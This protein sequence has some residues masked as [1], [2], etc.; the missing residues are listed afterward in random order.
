MSTRSNVKRS[1]LRFFLLVFALSTPFWLIGVVSTWQLLPGV[2][3]SALQIAC[4]TLAAML[5]VY[6]ESGGGAVGQLLKRSFDYERI[7]ARG[8]L[9]P[10]LLLMPAV[11]FV[12]Y[13]AMR[14][15]GLPLPVVK[16]NWSF[17]VPLFLALFL[18]G[19]AEELGWS[20]YA[21]DPLQERWGALGASVILGAVWAVWHLVPLVQVG[22]TALWIAA[23]FLATVALRTLHTWLYNNSGKSVFGQAL[24]HASCNVAWQ[25]FPNGGSHYDARVTGIVLVV[26][27]LVVTIAFGPGRLRRDG[28]PT[29]GWNE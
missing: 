15:V 13:A 9:M 25:M 17:V 12:S 18:A 3:V 28:A 22:R 11:M 19:L 1:P 10:I 7:E 26:V 21:I 20:G 8:W 2:P 5:L 24:F 16:L 6:R 4:P 14:L 27:A 29:R 23:W